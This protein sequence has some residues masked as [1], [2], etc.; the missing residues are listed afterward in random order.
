LRSARA[1]QAAA[2]RRTTTGAT[3]NAPWLRWRTS[4][5]RP[6]AS[7]RAGSTKPIL[8]AG[9]VSSVS[10]RTV[11]SLPRRSPH[12]RL[13]TIS[14]MGHGFFTPGLPRHIGQIVLDH[15]QING[16]GYV[17]S[18]RQRGRVAERERL[19]STSGELNFDYVCLLFDYPSGTTLSGE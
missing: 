19:D 13:E 8:S 16:A 15:H 5:S 18:P 17:T 11:G 7:S 12:A 3:P 6:K 9:D 10:C 2:A 4:G 1:R 14:G